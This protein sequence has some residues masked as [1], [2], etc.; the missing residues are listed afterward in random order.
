MNEI[1]QEL[2]TCGLNC[3]MPVLK[4]KQILKRMQPGTTLRVLA[5]DPGSAN[6]MEALCRQTGHTLLASSSQSGVFAFTIRKGE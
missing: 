1:T 5:S 4:T 3:P 2:D 6:D